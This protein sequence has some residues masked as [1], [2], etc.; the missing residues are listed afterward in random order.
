MNSLRSLF[1]RRKIV[2]GFMLTFALSATIALGIS[3]SERGI[4]FITVVGDVSTVQKELV[5]QKLMTGSI[6]LSQIEQVKQHLEAID[7]I[8]QVNVSLHWPDKLTVEVV[9][10]M[11]IAYWNDDAF[12]NEVGEVFRSEFLVGGDLPLLYGP[13]GQEARVMEH[14]QK[15]SR[16]ML[17][18]GH[19]IDVLKV[20]DR[21]AIEFENQHGVI[22]VLGNV[23]INQRLGRFLKVADALEFQGV[24]RVDAR[25]TN[26]VAVARSEPDNNKLL[27]NSIAERSEL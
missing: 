13:Q 7:W 26:G 4:N 14:Y 19:F 11:P 5:E 16:A 9:P 18:S 27:N 1:E 21:G 20:S 23:D 22:V 10:Q 12:I 17:K 24:V 25:Y 3:E 15:L 8:Y 2:I 6:M